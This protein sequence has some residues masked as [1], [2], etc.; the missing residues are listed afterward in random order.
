M[1]SCF[2]FPTT[3][4]VWGPIKLLLR[5]GIDLYLLGLAMAVIMWPSTLIAQATAV[6]S[7]VHR[8]SYTSQKIRL[9]TDVEPDRAKRMLRR[10]E[11]T[12]RHISSYWRTPLKGSIECYVVEDMKRWPENSFPNPSARA[13]IQFVGGVTLTK[14]Q[15][16]RRKSEL[17]AIVYATPAPGVVEHEIVHAYCFQTFG[18]HGPDWYKEGM[19]DVAGRLADLR[20][21]ARCPMEITSYLRRQTFRPVDEIVSSGSF[22]QPLIDIKNRLAQVTKNSVQ[23]YLAPSLSIWGAPEDEILQNVQSAYR[24]SWALCHF[25]VHSPNYSQR[26]RAYGQEHL[27]GNGIQFTKWFA[28]VRKELDF[29][30]GFFV[31]HSRPG[32]RVELCNW[33]WSL[34]RSPLKERAARNVSVRAAAGYQ[35]TGCSVSAGQ[36]YHYRTLGSC[37]LSQDGAAVTAAGDRSGRGKLVAVVMQNYKLSEEIELGESGSFSAP[38]SGHLH[39]RCRDDWD[40]LADNS[41]GLHVRLQAEPPSS[42]PGFNSDAIFDR[43]LEPVTNRVSRN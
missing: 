40:S 43:L 1:A 21:A 17:K 6:D 20:G 32:Y 30:F 4:T 16:D 22:T 28:D 27:D 15:V 2:C 37:C 11:K 39:L 41:G 8:R 31:G 5:W 9:H 23:T 38:S 35:A 25:L 3:C 19:A 29:E 10:M 36:S 14:M 24:W 7:E 13:L 34:P 42:S 12:L 26:F 18:K 33:D